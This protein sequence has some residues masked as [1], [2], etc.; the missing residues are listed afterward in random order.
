MNGASQVSKSTYG[1]DGRGNRTSVAIQGG[2][3]TT[4]AYDQANHLTALPTP[5]GISTTTTITDPRGFKTQEE[6]LNGRLVTRTRALGTALQ[7]VWNYEYDSRTLT[8][9]AVNDPLGRATTMTYDSPG[10]LLTEN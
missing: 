8:Q 5:D 1:F 10:N 3:T 6:Y 4:L 2:A 7:P 9:T